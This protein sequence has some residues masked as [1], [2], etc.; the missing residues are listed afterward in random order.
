MGKKEQ[1]LWVPAPSFRLRPLQDREA[2]APV[3]SGPCSPEWLACAQPAAA[4]RTGVPDLKPRASS[5][6]PRNPPEVD[7]C[8]G[9]SRIWKC[10]L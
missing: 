2:R 5:R 9:E 6:F 1:R 10:R 3:R 7:P 4:L 8:K